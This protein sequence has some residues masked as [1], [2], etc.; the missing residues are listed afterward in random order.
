M[1]YQV[2]VRVRILYKTGKNPDNGT[3][4]ETLVAA[5][6]WIIIPSPNSISTQAKLST[7]IILMLLKTA[8]GSLYMRDIHFYARQPN[9]KIKV[10]NKINL[11]TETDAQIALRLKLLPNRI[12]TGTTSFCHKMPHWN[13]WCS[14]SPSLKR[15]LSSKKHVLIILYIKME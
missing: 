3:C 15:N 10:Y 5:P 14:L 7:C 11:H 8:G 1:Q 2:S 4:T 9:L 12:A 6:T 13:Q